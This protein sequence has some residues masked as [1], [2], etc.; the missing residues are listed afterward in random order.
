M[1][2]TKDGME[3]EDVDLSTSTALPLAIHV[4]LLH[5][6]FLRGEKKIELI[7]PRLL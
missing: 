6:N 1:G 7:I 5:L 2:R 4:N 3:P